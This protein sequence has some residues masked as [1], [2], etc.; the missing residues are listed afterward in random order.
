M[1]WRR[2][3]IAKWPSLRG[4]RNQK[5]TNLR[6]GTNALSF[7]SI[8]FA[9][10]KQCDRQGIFTAANLPTNTTTVFAFQVLRMGRVNK[11][12]WNETNGTLFADSIV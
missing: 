9:L 6:F 2:K 4:S 1:S 8:T 12:K 3:I 5:P 7:F 10:G 11:I